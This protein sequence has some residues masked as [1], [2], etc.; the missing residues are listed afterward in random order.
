MAEDQCIHILL[1]VIPGDKMV[2]KG[3]ERALIRPLSV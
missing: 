3:T 2:T 1:S